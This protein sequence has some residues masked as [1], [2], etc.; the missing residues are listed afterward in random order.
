M[1]Q[2]ILKFRLETTNEKLTPRTGVAILGEYLKGMNLE[3]FC[4]DNLP[5]AKRNNGYSAFEFIYPLILMLHSG[6]RFLDDIREI[7]VDKA[8]TRLL[9]IQNIPTANAFS[10]YLRKHGVL[11]EEGMR[12]INK[13]F[14]KQFLKSIENEELILDI[15]ATFIEAHKNTAK[16]SYKDAPGYMPMVG[17]INNGWVIDVDFREGNEAPASKNLEFIKQCVLQLPFGK[18]FDRFRA[19]SASYQAAIFNYCEDKKILFT[20]MAKKNKNV[21][22]SIKSIKDEEWKT[23]SLREK[24]A[25]FT[26]TMQDTNNAF[27]MIVIKKDITPA[28]PTLEEYISDEVM[29]EHE[30]EIYYCIAT[31]DNDSTPE[32]IIKLHR[33]RGETSENKI[34]ELKNG[35]NMSYLPTSNFE[36][37]SFYFAIGTLAYN[38]FLLFKQILDSNLQKH[39]IKTIRYK[40]YNIAGKVVLHARKITLKVNEQFQELFQN[41][42]YRAYNESLQ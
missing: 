13:K 16:W 10:K 6:G 38:L 9:K 7:K 2:T 21:F 1:S 5:K 25:E 14:L 23:F 12:K 3:S 35:F 4:N 15:D 33:Q 37:N 27:R 34:K 18:K 11:G 8:L 19:D 29:A 17:H 39:T 31:N 26:H 30:D 41:I 42:R 22:K 36:A 28:L 32:E 24:V 20:V 40:L